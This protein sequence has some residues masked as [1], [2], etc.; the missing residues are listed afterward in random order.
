MNHVEELIDALALCLP[1][2]DPEPLLADAPAD[3][4]QLGVLRWMSRHLQ[5]QNL[6]AYEEWTEYF[7]EIPDLRPLSGIDFSTYDST[8]IPALLQGVDWEEAD[9]ELAYTL[10]YELPYLEHINGLLRSHELRLVDLLPF[11]NA[12]ILCVTDDA[13]KIDR[14]SQCLQQ[15][16]MGI[17][18][19]D[20]LDP[21]QVETYVKELLG[22]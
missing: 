10:P 9:A 15:F 11:E 18:R 20:G 21:S 17:N 6:L 19:R 3:A 1:Q 4:N 13:K 2:L 14:L 16:E 5:Q 7:G 8:F 22:S 12:Y